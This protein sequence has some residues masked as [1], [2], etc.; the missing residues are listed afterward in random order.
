MTKRKALALFSGGLDS[1]LAVKLMREQGIDVE[2]INFTSPFFLCKNPTAGCPSEAVRVA[3]ELGVP[4]TVIE[5]GVDFLEMI[6]APRHG[7]GSGMNP[8]IDCRIFFLRK[9]AEYMAE[10]GADFIVT[11][12]VLGQRP[13]SQRK[14]A[15][16]LVER[17]SGLKGLLLRPLSA[18]FLEPT[19][20]E[21][22]G[23]VDRER[24][25][26]VSGRSRKE[27]MRLASEMGIE[28]YP[29]PAGGCLLTEP[30]FLSKIR[31]IFDHAD[32]LNMLDFA[33][34]R[35]GRHFRIGAR[36]KAIVGRNE[37]E[38]K[39]LESMARPGDATLRWVDGGSPLCVVTGDIRPD[40]LETAARILLR[41]TKAASG[42]QCSIA[43]TH[44]GRGS[45]LSVVH[46]FDEGRI[47]HFR[48]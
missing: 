21:Q 19:V 37:A 22:E 32:T 18:K 17:E 23:W 31:D 4:I 39:A 11:G 28:G 7:Y 30:S 15:M 6:R 33:L 16:L 25:P 26:A 20:P 46:E 29:I 34:L 41:Y 24:L 2:A 1:I 48:L 12:E 13:L 35:T 43:V 27:Q 38:N 5:L 40:L 47:E 44:N 14:E 36:T 10:C 9:A 45:R 8:C 3:G 42:S